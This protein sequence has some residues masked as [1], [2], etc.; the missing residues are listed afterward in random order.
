MFCISNPTNGGKDRKREKKAHE[1]G[2]PHRLSHSLQQSC[3]LEKLLR[4]T[5]TLKKKKK[6][7]RTI[8]TTVNQ[9]IGKKGKREGRSP[10][11]GL[12]GR[13]IGEREDVSPSPPLLPLSRSG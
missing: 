13:G 6:K 10:S 4:S 3:S 9:R 2:T 8:A 7:K 1:G 11:N 12:L 5:I